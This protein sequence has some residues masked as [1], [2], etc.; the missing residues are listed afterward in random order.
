LKK[1]HVIYLS[2]VHICAYIS[3]C[4]YENQVFFNFNIRR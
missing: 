4:V 3:C 1:V 2:M